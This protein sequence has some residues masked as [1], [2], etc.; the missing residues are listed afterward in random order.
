MLVL[1]IILFITSVFFYILYVP[2]FSF[3]LFAFLLILP[4]ILF[5]MTK[6]TARKLSV[7][8]V[9]VQSTTG[10]SSK[11]PLVLKIENRSVLPAANLIIEIEYFNSLDGIKNVMKINTPVYPSETQYLTMHISGMHYGTVELRIKRC[12]VVD[13]L[14]LFKIKLRYPKSREIFKASSFT[15]F[16]EPI[17][18][19]NNIANYAEMGLETD[20]YS[21]TSKGDDPSEIFDVRDYVEGDK[22]SR[23]HWKLTAKQDKTIVKDYSLPISNSIVIMV[24]LDL[25]RKDGSCHAKYDTMI[26][27]AA[28]ISFHLIS[29]ETP[30]R[31]VWYDND[32]S[33]LMDISV[34]DEESH[35]LLV[36]M[37]L[38]A[39][40]CSEKD[41]APMHYANETERFKCGHLMYISPKNNEG[42]SELLSDADTAYKYT[43]MVVNGEQTAAGELYD[44]F[45]QIVPIYPGRVAES[46][47]ELSF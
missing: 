25:D 2:A 10:R 32:N 29:N 22:I 5:I 41:L 16:P 40:L 3:Y 8:F 20:E 39:P 24:D 42:V 46:I 26:E 34:T 4:F 17:A 21:K 18:I 31:V 11:I 6:L 9:T 44:E 12:G 14:R 36:G 37:L 23:I 7:D 38:K 27:T 35:R 28:A 30:H 1:Y 19:E 47:Q 45:A 33:R 13:M 43:Y 15:I